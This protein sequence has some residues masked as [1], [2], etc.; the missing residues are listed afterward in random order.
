MDLGPGPDGEA[1]VGHVT[2]RVKDEGTIALH[3]GPG[4][5]FVRHEQPSPVG[6]LIAVDFVNPSGALLSRIACRVKP[7]PDA[8]KHVAHDEVTEILQQVEGEPFVFQEVIDHGSE[9]IDATNYL[10]NGMVTE[11]KYPR[12][13][14]K[15]F[16]DGNPDAV[17]DFSS[18]PG[19][20]PADQAIVFVD[21]HDLQRGHAGDPDIV[22]YKD[23]S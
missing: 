4:G 7:T 2:L 3:V 18:P 16:E 14:V 15:A 8:V 12:V 9:P 1:Y 5:T 6:S 17:T 11:F 23:V 22:N 13:I 19:W 21:N 20:L 10:E